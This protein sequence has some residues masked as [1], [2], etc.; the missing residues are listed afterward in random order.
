[1]TVRRRERL[2]G[3]VVVRPVPEARPVP[4]RRGELAQ[5]VPPRLHITIEQPGMVAPP[6][7][8]GWPVW[9]RLVGWGATI[10]GTALLLIALLGPPHVVQSHHRPPDLV[11]PSR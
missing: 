11:N 7:V 8:E 10:I 5:P 2:H 1:M 4:V 9:K 6:V 3:E